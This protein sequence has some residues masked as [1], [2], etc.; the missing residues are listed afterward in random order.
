MEYDIQYDGYRF[1][2]PTY[3][4]PR[5]GPEI[6]NKNSIAA[7][8]STDPTS[9]HGT[10][11]SVK[12]NSPKGKTIESVS[13]KDSA[14]VTSDSV[15]YVGQEKPKL[16][17]DFVVIIKDQQNKE[18]T[19]HL[20]NWGPIPE[21]PV[22]SNLLTINLRPEIPFKIFSSSTVVVPCTTTSQL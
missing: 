4:F 21:S 1:F 20:S 19:A 7:P 14:K 17:N 15:T 13:H 3:I 22:L 18:L 5:Y 10:F 9:Q 16:E 8:L 6:V 11:I 2:I 12:L